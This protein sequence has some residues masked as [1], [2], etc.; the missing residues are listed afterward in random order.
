[1]TFGDSAAWLCHAACRWLSWRP[2]EF[3]NA[4]PVEFALAMQE[5]GGP[6]AGL[7]RALIE[8]LKRRFPDVTRD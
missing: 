7:D 4:T 3:W 8:E 5:P 2:D 1:M 6:S